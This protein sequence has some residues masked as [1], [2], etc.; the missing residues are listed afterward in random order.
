MFLS[1][2]G[3]EVVF[4][5]GF[6][7]SN[8]LSRPRFRPPAGKRWCLTSGMAWGSRTRASASVSVPLR[9]IGGV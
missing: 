1:P 2:C 4:N 6:S 3:E 5:R 8:G 7:G 9:G